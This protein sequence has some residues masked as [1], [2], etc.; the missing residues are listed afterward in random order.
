MD[1]LDRALEKNG[2]DEAIRSALDKHNGAWNGAKQ[3]MLRAADEID[4]LRRRNEI[5]NAKLEMVDL[6]ALVLNTRPNYPSMG[7][8]EDLAISLRTFTEVV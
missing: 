6:F 7:A 5:M 8:T 3:L 1:A 4:D 2:M